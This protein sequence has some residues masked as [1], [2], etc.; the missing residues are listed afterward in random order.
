MSLATR[1]CREL[2]VFEI[3][4]P[5]IK[6]KIHKK[7]HELSRTERLQVSQELCHK[8]NNLRSRIKHLRREK[9]LKVISLQTKD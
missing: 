4:R 8:L 5:V 6:K 9:E 3:I 2:H 1:C 7:V